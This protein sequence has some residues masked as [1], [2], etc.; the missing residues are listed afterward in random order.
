MH[1]TPKRQKC[2]QNDTEKLDY[3]IRHYAKYDALQR[4]MQDDILMTK[5]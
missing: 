3:A 4:V 5:T 2:L 1:Q